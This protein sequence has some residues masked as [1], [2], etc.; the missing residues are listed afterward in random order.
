MAIG[1]AGCGNGDGLVLCSPENESEIDQ[2]FLGRHIVAFYSLGSMAASRYLL[3]TRL[4][5]KR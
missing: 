1:D 4:K 2:T 5:Y 3:L